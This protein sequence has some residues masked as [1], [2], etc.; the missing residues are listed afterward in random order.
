METQ[1]ESVTTKVDNIAS[2]LHVPMEGTLHT[3]S[4]LTSEAILFEFRVVK[5]E[6]N[7]E[8]APT[9]TLHATHPRME[10]KNNNL[11]KEL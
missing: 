7:L 10:R 4:P 11:A 5:E 9:K 2:F 6:T 8:I 1:L 3:S